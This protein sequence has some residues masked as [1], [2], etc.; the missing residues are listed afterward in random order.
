MSTGY[1]RGISRGIWRVTDSTDALNALN[2]AESFPEFDRVNFR[3]H[4]LGPKHKAVIIDLNSILQELDANPV[5]KSQF[6]N[7]V[8]RILKLEI[9]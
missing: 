7:A 6:I 9:L 3:I 5:Q 8:Q 1:W 2:D 4:I